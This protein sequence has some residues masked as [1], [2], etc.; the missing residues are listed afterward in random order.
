MKIN[1][2]TLRTAIILAFIIPATAA[3]GQ[4]TVSIT[5]FG[6]DGNGITVNTAAIQRAIDATAKTGGGK[7]II[8]AGRFVTGAL[9]LRS[10]VELHFTGNAVLMGSTNRLDYGK[11]NAK[12][13]IVADG[14]HNIAISG[15]GIID[16]QAHGLIANVIGLLRN[17][18]IKDAQWTNKRPSENNRPEILWFNNCSQVKI[19]GI[20]LKDSP[21]WV[22]SYNNCNGVTV[23]SI[24]VESTA[25]WNNDGI[26]VTDSRN[27]KITNSF[28]NTADDGICLKSEDP[29]GLSENIY[30]ANCTVR[31][32]ASAF[33]IGTASAGTF[34]KITV[35]HLTV[36]D[37]YRS[38][39]ALE[40]VDGG[41]LEDIDIQHVNAVNTGNAIFIRLG[42]R[43]KD[44]RYSTLRN[45]H[46]AHVKVEVPSGKPDIGYPMEGPKVKYPKGVVPSPNDVALS[47]S[48]ENNSGSNIA[49][50][51]YPHNVFPASITG[52]PGHHVSNVT[53]EDIQVKYEG[54]AD[55]AL[56]SFPYDS[57]SLITEAAHAYPE[58]SMFGELPCWGFYVRHVSGLTMKNIHLSYAKTD[59]R[60]ACIFDDVKQL[61]L[62]GVSIPSYN[63]APVMILNKVQPVS[64]KDLHFMIPEEKAVRIR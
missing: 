19:S 62:T 5:D 47:V 58:F 63:E 28:F 16:G 36:Y 11:G 42:H 64:L 26:D 48:P 21:G 52:L 30:I 18:V 31:S 24:R 23:D 43:N 13:L 6:A 53:L 51:E 17:G 34:R 60:P 9:L 45:V 44:E 59:F 46:I 20:T 10:G 35:R 33:K 27:V 3:Q 61:A 12:A 54:G 15:N 41:L 50:I 37:T 49:A 7:V 22:Q 14:Q 8:P 32:S 2:K 40:T 1:F 25:Y 29:Q 57:L 55:K 4:R 39:I 56:A 38:A